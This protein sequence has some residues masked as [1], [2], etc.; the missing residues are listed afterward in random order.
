VC[1]IEV[2]GSEQFVKARLAR[3]PRTSP[4][5]RAQLVGYRRGM[6]LPI[7][8]RDRPA[9]HPSPHKTVESLDAEVVGKGAD[10]L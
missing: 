4:G 8:V 1:S 5:D 3:R 9:A 2:K 6:Q 7:L 10:P